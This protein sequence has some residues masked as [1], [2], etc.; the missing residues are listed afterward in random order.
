MNHSG[1]L[2]PI[3]IDV[4]LVVV[5]LV[6]LKIMWRDLSPSDRRMLLPIILFFLL[7]ICLMV[8]VFSKVL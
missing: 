3:L 5:C 4:G 6:L 1:L 7:H 2:T 8:F